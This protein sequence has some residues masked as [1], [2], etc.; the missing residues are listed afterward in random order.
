[1]K[2]LA[3]IAGFGLLVLVLF[4]LAAPQFENKR[5]ALGEVGGL[6]LD[7]DHHQVPLVASGL[8]ALKADHNHEV[9]VRAAQYMKE[10]GSNTSVFREIAEIAAEADHECPQLALALDLAARSNSDSARILALAEAACR[11]DS[12]EDEAIWQAYYD[13][14][15]EIAVYPTVE[16]A[17]EAQG[18]P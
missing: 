1:M 6:L 10:F 4:L 11:V 12:P 9:I 13:Q 15:S 14:L 8:S 7:T 17:L 18:G 16:A 2:K 3:V 5:E